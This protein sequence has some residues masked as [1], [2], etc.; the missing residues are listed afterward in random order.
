MGRASPPRV[1]AARPR[2]S[3]HSP[4][5]LLRTDPHGCGSPPLRSGTASHPRRP[6]ALSNRR[7]PRHLSHRGSPA[8]RAGARRRTPPRSLPLRSPS[9]ACISTTSSRSTASAR[10]T[11]GRL[12]WR[13]SPSPSNGVRFSASSGRTAPARRRRWSASRDCGHPTRGGLPSS[14]SIRS[15]TGARCNSAS[16]VQL[17]EAQL[18]EADQGLGGGRL[19]ALALSGPRRRR[20]APPAARARREAQRV[21]HD[22]LRRPEAAPLHR[23]RAGERPGGRLPGRADDGARSAGPAGDLGPRGGASANAAR[24]SS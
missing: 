18:Q 9:T 20:R 19:L 21:V 1:A 13:R 17:Q 24:P 8:G 15:A 10:P 2:R 12:P 23:P 7:L 11:A 14:D 5:L 6:V 22:A 4:A 16:G 3:T